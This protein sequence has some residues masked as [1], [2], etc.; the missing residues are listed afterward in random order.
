M[1]S[2]IKELPYKFFDFG[3]IAKE[4][5]TEL[6]SIRIKH[7]FDEVVEAGPFVH[8]DSTE[9]ILWKGSILVLTKSSVTPPL[10][11]T[12]KQ[13]TQ[14]T[15]LMEIAEHI[16]WR[17]PIALR[18]YDSECKHTYSLAEKKF[19]LIVPDVDLSCEIRFHSN[20][21]SE[22]S[23][24]NYESNDG[25][26]GLQLDPCIL[27]VFQ[28]NQ[29]QLHE[30]YL[31]PSFKSYFYSMGGV[32]N[33][34]YH[35][36]FQ[37]ETELKEVLLAKYIT[38]F[39]NDVGSQ[40]PYRALTT[41]DVIHESFNDDKILSAE[42]ILHIN[43]IN[44]LFMN[45]F[46]F[47]SVEGT[48][49]EEITKPYQLIELNDSVFLS[50][51]L[52]VVQTAEKLFR[53]RTWRALATEL[54]QVCVADTK[55]LIVTLN[56]PLLITNDTFDNKATPDALMTR[57]WSLID[58]RSYFH[59]DKCLYHRQLDD[60]FSL[61]EKIQQENCTRV[62]IVSHCLNKNELYLFS[63]GTGLESDE[64]EYTFTPLFK[65]LRY[66]DDLKI[67]DNQTLKFKVQVDEA[68]HITDGNDEVV[69]SMAALEQSISIKETL[70]SKVSWM[71]YLWID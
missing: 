28:I 29:F 23:C 52:K 15:F 50:L 4:E 66:L 59:N 61:L 34:D 27:N 62:T 39:T 35:F 31:S 5:S 68:L 63:L 36:N 21:L 40:F 9:G 33:R 6:Q 37:M 20:N 19:D 26:E 2:S 38:I 8:F 44:T 69:I 30:I 25:D 12:N 18:M 24:V 17:Y 56:Y 7:K 46:F 22:M 41:G 65:Q 45:L 42:L 54:L 67:E 14:A 57:I 11:D 16:F 1:F 13:I 64:E 49:S 51:D 10:L 60:F 3:N 43:R 55:H 70:L 71:R 58:V 47:H 53:N 32:I 48:Q